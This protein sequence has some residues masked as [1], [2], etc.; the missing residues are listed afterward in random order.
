[1]SVSKEWAVDL[2]RSLGYRKVADEAALTLP[3]QFDM[4]QLIDF[5]NQHGISRSEL[6][7]RMGG[8]P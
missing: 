3:D 5:G 2:L 6:V 1:M 7:D 4:Q 8:S